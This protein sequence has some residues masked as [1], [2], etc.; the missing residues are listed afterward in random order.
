MRYEADDEEV[1]RIY[2][3]VDE[4]MDAS[5]KAQ[6]YKILPL[7]VNVVLLVERVGMFW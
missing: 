3:T 2:E 1:D 4:A 6:R 5:R 7:L